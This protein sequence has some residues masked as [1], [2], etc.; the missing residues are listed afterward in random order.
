MLKD[1][2]LLH[3]LPPSHG[4]ALLPR[5]LL[6]FVKDFV[7]AKGYFVSSLP[8]QIT[9]Q[10]ELSEDN[11]MVRP[12]VNPTQWPLAPTVHSA[13][14]VPTT[15]QAAFQASQKPTAS[16]SVSQ[17]AKAEPKHVSSRQVIFFSHN[18]VQSVLDRRHCLKA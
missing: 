1:S 5:T 16:A 4:S 3:L 6:L 18:R 11:N 9:I 10:V 7:R 13:D 8:L 2:S 14:D 15:S 12:R 17:A